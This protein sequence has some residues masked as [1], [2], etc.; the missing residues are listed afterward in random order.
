MYGQ[1]KTNSI[2]HL[3]IPCIIRCQLKKNF[4]LIFIAYMYIYKIYLLTLPYHS[5]AYILYD[6]QFYIFIEF[7]S[8]QRSKFMC[9]YLF[10]VLFLGYLS[11]LFVCFLLLICISFCFILFLSFRSLF[12]F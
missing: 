9:L 11:F 8:M 10:P 12:A 5:F 3:E 6:F 1:Y 2:A 7:L 4:F